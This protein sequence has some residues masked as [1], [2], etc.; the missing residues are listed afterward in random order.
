MLRRL[1]ALG[2]SQLMLIALALLWAGASHA[3]DVSCT[4]KYLSAEHVYLDAGSSQG[5]AVGMRG[6]VVRNGQAIGEVEIVFVAERSASCTVSNQVQEFLTGDNVVF[7]SVAAPV[8]AVEQTP[9]PS[10]QRTRA[11]AGT[12]GSSRNRNVRRLRGSIAVQWDHGE[13]TNERNLQ[14]DVYRLPFRLEAHDVWRGFKFRARGSFRHL[15]REGFSGSTPSSEWR[16]RIQEVA[17]IRDG[18]DD[19]WHFAIGRVGGRVTSAAGPF[20]GVSVN[21]RVGQN[22]RLGFFGGFAPEWGELGFGTDDHLAGANFHFNHRGDN[23]HLLDLVLAGIGRY[24]S[25]EISREYVM[26]PIFI[27]IHLITGRIEEVR[28]MIPLA[29]LIIPMALCTLLDESEPVPIGRP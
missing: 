29:Y 7:E 17:L 10:R 8:D 9:A 18:R 26:I 3:R 24:R 13:E 23:G 1:T 22:T 20:D 15:V 4:V 21:R 2:F 25:G 19:A 5:L 12:A 6:R 28:Q 27:A 11:T 16:N 14:T